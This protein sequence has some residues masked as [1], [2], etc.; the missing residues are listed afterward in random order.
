MPRLILATFLLTCSAWLALGQTS[1][2]RPTFDAAD[3]HVSAKATNPFPRTGPAHG[4]RYELKNVTMVDLVRIAYGYDN[5]KVLG[6]PNWLEMDRFDLTGKVSAD[7]T[8]ETH[9]LMLQSL[10]ED[11][12]KLVVRKETKP[13]PS[14][15]LA[16]GKKPQL[17]EATGQEEA[18]CRPQ[19]SGGMPGEGG[20]V[21]FMMSTNSGPPVTFNLGPG[22]TVQYQCRNMTMEAFVSNLRSM[23]GT[24]LGSAAI[25]DETGLKGPWNFDLKYSMQMMGMLTNDT[26]ERI[27]LASAIDKQLG[28]KLEERQTPTPVIVVEKVNQKPS[29]NPAGTAEALPPIPVPTEFEVATVKLND[30]SVRMP[31][32][33]M[34]PGGRLLV[35]GM[36]LRFIVNRAFNVNNND[37]VV[38]L[39]AFVDTDRYDITAKA[40]G[41]S[42]GPVDMEAMAPLLLSLLVD[43]FKM[44]YHTEDR[45]M[46]AYSLVA[47]K[48]KMKKA[49]PASRTFCK[50][51]QAAPGA[52][53]GSRSL[54]CQ[55]ATMA[56]VAERLQNL[57]PELNWPVADATELEGGWD[58]T[59]TFSMRMMAM[60]IGGMPMPGGGGR[61]GDAGGPGS[62]PSASEPSGGY[63]IFEAIEKQLGLK[64]EK[65]KRP[66][67]V[68]IIDHFES[69]PTEN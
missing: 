42:A 50:N 14:Y 36:P 48:P 10:L 30:G 25:V 21:R 52:P 43:R 20:T 19:S 64:L 18:G 13:L 8:A 32:F 35:E 9:K 54:Q 7:S 17:K 66:Q 22:M 47:A 1:E 40:P 2:P 57:S 59:L 65:Q 11:R 16:S 62:M 27:S 45:P 49:D 53:P 28:L 67:P 56:Q 38:G 46:T 68:F 26:G 24:S 61:G 34:Q 3:V 31:R 41:V 5:D 51:I 15:A 33:Q 29:D 60:G 55:N 39:P 37:R 12:F 4:G 23:I 6:G 44:K 58:F 63:T 69:K